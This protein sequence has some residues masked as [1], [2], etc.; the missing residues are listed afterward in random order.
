[1][2]NYS[3]KLDTLECKTRA[4]GT[5]V[6]LHYIIDDGELQ[7]FPLCG[8]HSMKK[9]D[10]WSLDLHLEFNNKIIIA[11]E[12]GNPLEEGNDIGIITIKSPLLSGKR[13]FTNKNK[14]WDYQLS[15]FQTALCTVDFANFENIT[16]QLEDQNT[17]K[18]LNSIKAFIF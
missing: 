14:D 12:E 17:R 18:S 5:E 7:R 4:K 6:Y 8:N 9:G 1:M 10:I 15:Y 16:I 3:I 11:L 13:S 2:A